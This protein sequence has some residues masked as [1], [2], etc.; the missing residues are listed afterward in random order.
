MKKGETIVFMEMG[1]FAGRGGIRPVSARLPPSLGRSNQGPR[2][3]IHRRRGTNWIRPS[4]RPVLGIPDPSSHPGHRFALL[5][6]LLYTLCSTISQFK[7]KKRQTFQ[8]IHTLH[9]R[10]CIM[11]R[12]GIL[13]TMAKGIGNGFPLGA[14]VTTMEIAKSMSNALHF[15]TYGGNPMASAVG[16]AVLDV[17]F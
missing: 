8:K 10:A 5:T 17:S 4:R 6:K 3:S 15:N 1:V 14:V 9:L 11:Q 12:I 7:N 2:R 13:V 16:S